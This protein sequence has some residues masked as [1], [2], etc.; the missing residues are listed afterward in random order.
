MN[1]ASGEIEQGGSTI[2]QQ[3]VKILFVGSER[4]VTRKIKEALFAFEL[5]SKN[6]KDAVLVTY[7][8]TVYFGRGAYGVE[9]AAQS[10]FGKPASALDLARVRDAWLASSARPSRYGSSASV[11]ETTKRR[12]LVLRQML[13]QGSSASKRSAAHARRH[14]SSR[15]ARKP[16]R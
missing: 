9:S 3:L 13:D 14:W 1:A 7:L 5:E 6:D 12:D 2:T 16:A 11:V 10:Y 4:S 8:N 15:P